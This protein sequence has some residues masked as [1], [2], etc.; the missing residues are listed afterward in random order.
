M[1]DE[2]VVV[3]DS[4]Q[5]GLGD[6]VNLTELSKIAESDQEP[7]NEW[8]LKLLPWLVGWE[9]AILFNDSPIGDDSDLLYWNPYM[10]YDQTPDGFFYQDDNPENGMWDP[11]ELIS[12]S[13]YGPYFD[14]IEEFP[15]GWPGQKAFEEWWEDFQ[16]QPNDWADRDDDG[17]GIPNGM[18][19]NPDEPWVDTD[20]DGLPDY[21]DP[22]PETPGD[23]DPPIDSDGDGIPDYMDPYPYGEDSPIDPDNDF[24]TPILIDPE[25]APPKLPPFW[26]IG[27]D[28]QPPIGTSDWPYEPISIPPDHLL[29]PDPDIWG[30]P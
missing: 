12:P 13:P 23:W 3:E 28:G 9:D 30:T 4:D 22:D 16:D 25:L 1:V 2:V 20:G 17:D 19:D 8:L 10:Y 14:P 27:G 15:D 5:E 29:P 7:L 11:G 24:E 26:G 21:V 6:I 18:D